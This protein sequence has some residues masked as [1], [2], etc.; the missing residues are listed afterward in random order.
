VQY[1]ASDG[2][3]GLRRE[4]GGRKTILLWNCKIWWR[5]TNI[6][7]ACS[8][9]LQCRRQGVLGARFF[10]ILMFVFI[11]TVRGTDNLVFFRM[12]SYCFLWL[13]IASCYFVVFLIALYWFVWLQIVSCYFVVF[14]IALYWFV[15]LQIASY[16][17]VVFHSASYWLLWLY[18]ASYYFEAFH[19]A[20][21]SFVW[22][23]VSYSSVILLNVR[24]DLC[25]SVLLRIASYTGI[26]FKAGDRISWPIFLWISEITWGK[27]RTKSQT[28]P[29]SIRF[30]FHIMQ[31]S[32]IFISFGAQSLW[33][34]QWIVSLNK[35]KIRFFILFSTDP[36][37]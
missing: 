25:Y 28:G 18:I 14:L 30:A 19:I 31:Y 35:Q 9:A 1:L 32:L 26:K 21:Y 27:F 24:T 2:R 6:R 23:Y 7:T 29:R 4:V 22:F 5:Y 16:I 15:W 34:E 12:M 33:S 20:S 10:L 17:F 11:G 8:E 36:F 3:H 37:S 13:Q